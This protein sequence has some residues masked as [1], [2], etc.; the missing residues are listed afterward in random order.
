MKNKQ[1]IFYELNEVPDVIFERYKKKSKKFNKLI[2]KFSIYKTKSLDECQLSPWITWST[3]HRGVTFKDHK[4]E[5]L[6][7]DVHKQ[8]IEY[9]PIWV[10]LKN[11]GVS[12]G[13]YGSMHSNHLPKD[14]NEYDFYMPDPFS[15]HFKCNPKILEPIQEF[16]L[17][18]T[19]A[20]SRNVKRSF[21]N[22][23]SLNFFKSLFKSGIK[24]KTF[25][26]LFIQLFY[27]QIDK[28]KLCRRRVYQSVINFDIYLNLLKL[29][30]PRFSTFFTNHVASSMHRF[31]E[32]AYPKDFRGKNKQS[33]KWINC[34]KNEI[35][36]AM[37]VVEI[38]LNSLIKYAEKNNNCEIWI[39]TSMGQ[40]P[41][42]NY[43]PVEYQLYIKKPE[44][45]IEFFRINPKSFIIKPAMMPRW[46]LKGSKNDIEK[47]SESLNQLLIDGKACE[48]MYGENT[49]TIKIECINKIPDITFLGRRIDYKD[50][51]LELVKIDDNSGSSAYH[52]PEGVLMIYGQDSERYRKNGVISTNHLKKLILESF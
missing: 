19:R 11:K 36:F 39:C 5:N 37:K 44:K 42:I 32:A 40:S 43:S 17:N 48:Q 24:F 10:D 6:G 38:Q 30:S 21:F 50:I 35:D 8:N 20:S 4:I 23:L 33:L 18:L 29:K 2:N 3:V 52:I 25:L 27:E 9:P 41:V 15:D 47:L 14:F 16:Q 31:W 34:Y 28:K 51:G 1:I 7:Q 22:E 12:V 49:L 45:L 46:T 13:V 26:N